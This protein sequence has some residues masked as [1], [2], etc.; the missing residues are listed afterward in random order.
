MAK[1]K[2]I[3]V[4]NDDRE[5]A[6]ESECEAHN[7]WLESQDSI[8]KYIKYAGLE[9][10]QAGLLRTHVAGYLA[11]VKAGQPERT[12]EELATMKKAKEEEAAKR[13]KKAKEEPAKGGSEA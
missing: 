9:K 5:F 7:A 11:H 3:F 6:T 10:A 4:A 1:T 8:E 13:S 12:E 2:T